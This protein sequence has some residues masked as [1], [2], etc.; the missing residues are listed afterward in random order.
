MRASPRTG[1]N[2]KPGLHVHHRPSCAGV[3]SNAAVLHVNPLPVVTIW[4]SYIEILPTMTTT[5]FSSVAPNPATTYTWYHDGNLMPGANADTLLVDYS[6]LG[7]YQLSVTDIN[8]C[9]GISNIVEIKDSTGKMFIYPNPSAG[10]FVVR[11]PGERNTVQQ[12][13]VSVYSNTG[14]RLLTKPYTQTTPYEQIEMDMRRFG[15]GLFWVE[16]LDKNNKRLS[17]TKLLVQ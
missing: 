8:G 5:L 16:V 13:T 9:T 12:V 10:R 7:E 1:G 2:T 11:L 15:K 3:I 6:G 17:M 4:A 14:V